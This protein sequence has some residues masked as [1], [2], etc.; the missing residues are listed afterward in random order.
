MLEL[1]EDYLIGGFIGFIAGAFVA[2]FVFRSTMQR[3]NIGEVIEW[4]MV[5]KTISRLNSMT[6]ILNRLIADMKSSA[7]ELTEKVEIAQDMEPRVEQ[8][9][10]PTKAQNQGK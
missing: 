8:P 10:K 3:K 5:E 9:K 1:I 2:R 7:E 6:T 4:A